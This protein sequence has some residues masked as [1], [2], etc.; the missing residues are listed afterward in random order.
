M[1]IIIMVENKNM[2]HHSFT[3][4]LCKVDIKSLGPVV[5]NLQGR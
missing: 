1:F 5:Q 2:G 4:E 3:E